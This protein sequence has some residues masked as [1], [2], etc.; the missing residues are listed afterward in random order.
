[1]P[2]LSSSC[3][4]QIISRRFPADCHHRQSDSYAIPPRWLHVLAVSVRFWRP[5]LSPHQIKSPH[6][7]FTLSVRNTAILSCR[8]DIVKGTLFTPWNAGCS[9]VT[10][11]QKKRVF[12]ARTDP[13]RIQPPRG[14][15]GQKVVQK[16]CANL[17]T[18]VQ[19]VS[20]CFLRKERMVNLLV[21]EKILM[22]ARYEKRFITL[23]DVH[24][25]SGLD[26]WLY[27]WGHIVGS[28]K[29]LR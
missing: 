6:V 10:C 24:T 25:V 17:C 5:Y 22:I 8:C 16:N 27:N 3:I 20:C 29:G 21:A 9:P 4:S 1:M 18:I 14:P 15:E 12:C 11:A 23:F 13:W 2:R 26:M 7:F 19:C 28:F